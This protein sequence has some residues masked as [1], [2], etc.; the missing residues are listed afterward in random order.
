MCFIVN[1]KTYSYEHD[2]GFLDKFVGSFTCS[3]VQRTSFSFWHKFFSLTSSICSCVQRKL[4]IFFR[5]TIFLLQKLAGPGIT[6][7]FVLCTCQGKTC[8]AGGNLVVCIRSQ[9]DRL[10]FASALFAD[11]S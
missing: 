10:R 5:L 1:R 9:A 6:C 7:Q 8:K 3:C 2:Q 4:T 11:S